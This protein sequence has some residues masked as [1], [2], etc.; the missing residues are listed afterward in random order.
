M[1]LQ[2]FMAAQL[3]R[4]SGWF[5]SLVMGRLLDRVNR[6]IVERTLELLEIKPEHDV[7]EIGFGGGLAL[8]RLLETAGN[9]VISGVDISPEMV[10]RAEK[11]F[12]DY[13]RNGRLRVQLGDVS[14]LPFAGAAFD[15][16]FTVNTIYFWPEPQAGMQ[17]ICRV[18]K[19]GGLAAIAIRS[20]EKMEQHG[21]T[22]HG[23]RLFSPDD[24]V[25][26][27]GQ[28]GL[29][30]VRVDHRDRDKWYDQVVIVGA[31]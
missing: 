22:R 24:V 4:P 29:R 1:A 31:R 13:V 3:R 7:L 23:F 20:R 18:L 5:G 21:V 30:E 28:A 27:M 19:P 9:G 17:E 14:R 15:R 12:R 8:S 11:R 26:L 25:T 10:Q 6:Q 2:R 16:V